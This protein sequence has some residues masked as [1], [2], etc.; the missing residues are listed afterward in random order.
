MGA[1][2][3]FLQSCQEASPIHSVV[4]LLDIQEDQENYILVNA[5]QLMLQLN[6]QCGRPCSPT[7]VEAM[8]DAVKADTCHQAGVNNHL[9]HLPPRPQNAIPLGVS[10]T[11]GDQD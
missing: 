7:C 4:Q 5:I 2:T 8:E 10:V 3:V 9:H 6:L 1:S 11:L